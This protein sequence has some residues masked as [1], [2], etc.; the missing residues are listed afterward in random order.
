MCYTF[1]DDARD[2]DT[3]EVDPSKSQLSFITQ[4]QAGTKLSKRGG[5]W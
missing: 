3:R 4:S 5:P 2:D 1:F